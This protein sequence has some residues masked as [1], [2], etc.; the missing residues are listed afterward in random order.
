MKQ[1]PLIA[2]FISII[3]VSF[4][5]IIIR[6]CTA[7]PLLISFYRLLFTTV[8]LLPIL[9]VI[10]RFRKQLKQISLKELVLMTIIGII[11]A[12]HFTFW[13]TS[14]Q[15]T[16]VASSVILVTAHPILVGPLSY[17]FLKEKISKINIAGIFLSLSGVFTLVYGNYSG[18]FDQTSLYGNILAFLGGIAAGFYIL[19]GRYMRRTVS[20]IIYAIMVYAI[21][22]IVLLGFIGF[23]ETTLFSITT[24]DLLLILLMAIVSG[25]GGH[26]LYNWSLAHI[27]ASLASVALLGEPI[28]SAILALLIPWINE[29]PTIWTLIGGGIILTGVYLTAKEKKEILA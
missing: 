22:T 19:G 13:I 2:L 27:R 21:S 7:K 17:I 9:I 1:T 28:G 23:S 26:T 18:A 10:P 15:F 14:L 25:I 11:L 5:A 29:I 24:K 4:A 6:T 3:G 20:V 8:L 16:S 12:L